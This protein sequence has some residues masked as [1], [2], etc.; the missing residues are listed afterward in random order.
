MDSAETAAGLR[1]SPPPVVEI[2]PARG[3]FYVGFDEL[4]R[5]RDLLVVLAMR[6]LKVRYKQSVLGIAW[7]I[8]QPL[9][10]MGIFLV[11]FSLIGRKPSTPGIPYALSALTGLIT[12]QLFAFALSQ[13]GNSL[14]QNQE[15]IRKVY[16]PRLLAPVAPLLTGLVDF[17]LGCVVLASLM[18]YFGAL[19]TWTALTAPLFLLLACLS[20]LGAGLW[21]SALNALYRDVKHLIPF[22][23]Q[24]GLFVSPVVYDTASVVPEAWRPVFALNPMVGA[25]EGLRWS[26]LSAA[27][28]SP[29]QLL[30]SSVSVLVLLLGGLVYFRR[31]ERSFA[32]RV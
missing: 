29:L 30:I 14:V 23:L 27:P 3:W 18:V 8:L 15:L 11:F 5:Y 21:L 24:V 13:S 12:W 26:L 2:T 32:D 1:N 10:T 7:A 16:F 25:I 6:D 31:M 22:F 9:L 20:A 19:P 28:P 17:G 4:W